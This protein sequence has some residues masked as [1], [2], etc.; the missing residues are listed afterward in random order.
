[1]NHEFRVSVEGASQLELVELATAIAD[2][3]YGPGNWREDAPAFVTLTGPC[4]YSG[5]YYF[6]DVPESDERTRAGDAL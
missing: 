5:E 4:R 1:M 6:T 2:K 3:F